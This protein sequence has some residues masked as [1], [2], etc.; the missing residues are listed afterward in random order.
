MYLSD[1]K[2]IIIKTKSI[3]KYLSFTQF[4]VMK[5]TIE[6][7]SENTQGLLSVSIAGAPQFLHPDM[8]QRFVMVEDV[9]MLTQN[10]TQEGRA[11]SPRG[12]KLYNN[13]N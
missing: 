8:V 10:G 5:M 13:N 9:R 3:I 7:A 1:Q 2:L 4:F 12:H 11:H 6:Q